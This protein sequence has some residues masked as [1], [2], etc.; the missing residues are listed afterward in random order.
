MTRPPVRGDVG[1]DDAADDDWDDAYDD[2][3]DDAE[4]EELRTGGGVARKILM[5]LV[6]VLALC[7]F[8][9]L[10]MGLW[11]RSQLDPGGEPGATVR[12]TI[13]TG[14]TT[15]EI[16]RLLEDAEVIPDA[17]AFRYY[18]RFKG[19][20]AFQ[21]GDYEFQENSAAW[22]ALGVL[23]GEPLPPEF[24]QFTVPEGLTISQIP[25]EVADDVAGFD[26]ARIAEILFT[27]QVR[28][29]SLPPEIPSL[30]G[31][32]FPDTYQVEA[33]QD[34]LAAL[35]RMAQ[36]FDAVAAEIGLTDGAA[37]LGFTPYEIVV[38]ASL[39]QE[40]Y[41]IVEEMPQIARVIYNR[42]ADGEPLGIDAT[43]CYGLNKPCAELTQSDLETETPYN[44]RL[45]A[46]LPPTPI[47]AP[48]RAA[49]L[50]AL[51]PAEGDWIYYVRD[52]DESRTPPGGHF[53]TASAREFEQVKDQ[54]EEA[55]L[56]CG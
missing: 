40:E 23:Q 3:Y 17:Q 43:I 8:V 20:E 49:L 13:P 41:G 55:G 48:G 24:A 15:S 29:A 4:Y 28:P 38:I 27:G 54:C 47:A 32:L 37:R 12:L 45:N 52:P 10:G 7:F 50:A 46:G 1:F 25:A 31:F 39:I 21:A 35:N 26:E 2:E 36:Q 51:N 14:S 16:A 53:F 22:D 34:E 30:E 18:L 6:V 19:E 56:G 33:G 9:A 11:V 42:L 5:V 44:T